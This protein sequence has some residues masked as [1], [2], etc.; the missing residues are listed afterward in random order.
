MEEVKVLGQRDRAH[1]LK[2]HQHKKKNLFW[3]D[4]KRMEGIFKRIC[5][6]RLD[7]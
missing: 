6:E 5:E 4:E 1:Y 2:H 3:R 7:H